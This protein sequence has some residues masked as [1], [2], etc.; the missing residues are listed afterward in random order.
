[1]A[2]Y[3]L[4]K[5]AAIAAIKAAVT[6][7]TSTLSDGSKMIDEGSLK[8]WLAD[9]GNAVIASDVLAANQS[10]AVGVL[11]TIDANPDC[12]A[13]VNFV[14]R[15]NW[16]TR[17]DWPTSQS[18]SQ[19][20]GLVSS[21]YQTIID[22]ENA[23]KGIEQAYEGIYGQIETVINKTAD[24]IGLS[25][26][27]PPTA[28]RTL[29][30]RYLVYTYITD[31]RNGTRGESAPSPV[32]LPITCSANALETVTIGA[33]PVGRNIAGWRVYRSNTSTQGAEFQ[34]EGEFDIVNKSV[35]FSQPAS[36]LG[37]V[38]PT[39]LWIEP[40]ANLRGLVNMPNGIMA[41]FFDNT[42]CF[43][44][45]FV[46]YAWPLGYQ[47]TVPHPIV[48]LGTFGQT[49]VVMHQGGVDYISGSDSASMSI[50]KDVS[51][52]ACVSFK[53]VVSVEGGVMYSSP[54]GLCLATGQGVDLIT[55][56]SFMR[57]EWQTINPASIIG[58]YA[59]QTYFGGW[60]N[61]FS[62]GV[63]MLHLPT[64]KLTTID[65]SGVGSAVFSDTATDTLYLVQGTS[66]LALFKGAD[67]RVGTW[68]SKIAVMPKH[69]SYAW[70]TVE[71]DFEH[72]ITVHWFID[73]VLVYTIPITSRT[74]VR[75]P[76]RR[77]LEHEIE[78][79][80]KARWNCITLASS[81]Q[82]LQAI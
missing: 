23:V 6:A 64:M 67:R 61:A 18:L 79:T 38:C 66:V 76:A 25:A 65:V 2:L 81:T 60:K 9:Q 49:L 62:G 8:Q 31:L 57:P 1:M 80:T 4:G 74:P 56:N 19:G 50:Q 7:R 39:T 10:A 5:V 28:Q 11:N 37:E 47:L 63:F 78:V 52:Q 41:G 17:S 27:L 59:E 82:E 42:V 77:G 33:E 44:E 71:S 15:S 46:P 26:K 68:R 48:A 29:E 69:L 54:D 22:M 40:P 43:S 36:N 12:E 20:Q 75:L 21:V 55:K 70:L 53:S 30:T 45:P 13:L 73:G 72:P 3:A 51:K 32:S 24:A 34:L 14:E 58:G 16:E 35:T